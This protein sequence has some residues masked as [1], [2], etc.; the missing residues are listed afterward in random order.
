MRRG[1]DKNG[2]VVNYFVATIDMPTVARN[3]E[4]E[5][6]TYFLKYLLK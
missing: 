2:F 5:T 1:M 3:S 6:P 4:G